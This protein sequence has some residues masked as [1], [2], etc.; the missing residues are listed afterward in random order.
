MLFSIFLVEL[1]ESLYLTIIATARLRI[2]Q[3]LLEFEIVKRHD[4]RT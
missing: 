2:M 3:D 1:D 4:P